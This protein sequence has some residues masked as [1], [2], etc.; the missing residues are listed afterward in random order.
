VEQKEYHNRKPEGR[1]QEGGRGALQ[2][3]KKGEKKK[4]EAIR[5]VHQTW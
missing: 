4:V 1:E 2:G 3:K 5:P